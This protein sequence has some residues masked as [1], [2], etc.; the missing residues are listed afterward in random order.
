MQ[1]GSEQFYV[2]DWVSTKQKRISHSSYGAE[3]LAC[4]EADDRGYYL[5]MGLR[6]LFPKANMRNEITID[7]RG[8]YDTISTLHEG[9][10]YSLRQ[11]VQRIRDS[12]ESGKVD[13]IRWDRGSSNVADALPKR[14]YK[15]WKDLKVIC[16]T[17]C[18]PADLLRG[19]SRHSAEWK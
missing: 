7:S 13:V 1:D 4:A 19:Q 3:I 6:S 10:E 5:K 16:Y 15:L 12:F 8:L 11:T 2:I 14:N 18:L 17:G 9:C